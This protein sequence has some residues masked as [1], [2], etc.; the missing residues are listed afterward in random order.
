[1]I[2][3]FNRGVGIVFADQQAGADHHGEYQLSNHAERNEQAERGG[4]HADE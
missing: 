2:C 3:R 4:R 1:M